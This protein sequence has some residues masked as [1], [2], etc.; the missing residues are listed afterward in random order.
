MGILNIYAPNQV[1]NRNIFWLQLHTL[2]PHTVQKW[3]AGGDFNMIEDPRDRRGGR[4]TSMHGQELAEWERLIFLLKLSDVWNLE[5][6][7]GDKN[8][9]RFSR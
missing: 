1:V 6:F 7:N 2:L 4:S 3:I 9:L 5:N 8:S